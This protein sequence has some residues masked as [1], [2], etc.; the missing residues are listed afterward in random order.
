[1][2]W[3]VLRRAGARAF[4]VLVVV[5]FI[6]ERMIDGLMGSH[7]ATGAW[8]AG[9][10]LA[11]WG[12]S[13]VVLGLAYVIAQR[14]MVDEMDGPPR[15]DWT[16]QAVWRQVRQGAWLFALGGWLVV[17]VMAAKIWLA[18]VNP[19]AGAALWYTTV[20]FVPAFVVDRRPLRVCA[21]N[22]LTLARSHSPGIIVA[23]LLSLVLQWGLSIV[24][25]A[26]FG[27]VAMAVSSEQVTGAL[28]C[29]IRAAAGLVLAAWTM[30]LYGCLRGRVEGAAQRVA[31]MFD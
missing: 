26:G 11:I 9:V 10:D 22:A 15:V 16:A 12:A 3:R 31:D 30:G 1:M 29:L 27:L 5:G 14:M 13:L 4:A 6:P 21:R 19:G 2:A 20:Y 24:Q 18:Q 8:E 28:D 7:L 23:V 25:N 17:T